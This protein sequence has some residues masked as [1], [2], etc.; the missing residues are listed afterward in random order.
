MASDA[1]GRST[2]E[3]LAELVRSLTREIRT[4]IVEG[5]VIIALGLSLFGWSIVARAADPA[6][7]APQAALWSSIPVVLLGVSYFVRSFADS[8]VRSKVKSIESA[9]RREHRTP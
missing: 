7:Q 9:A 5:V 8:R 3:Q 4:G 6:R 1:E 2:G